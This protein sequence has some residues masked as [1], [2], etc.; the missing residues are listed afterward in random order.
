[1]ARGTAVNPIKLLRPDLLDTDLRGIDALRQLTDNII[2]PQLISFPLT[3]E[4]L[5]RRHGEHDQENNT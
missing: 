5:E 2:I 4:V 3:E 1:M